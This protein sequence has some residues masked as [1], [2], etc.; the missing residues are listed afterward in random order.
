[1]RKLAR[2]ERIEFLRNHTERR[3]V[4]GAPERLMVLACALAAIASGGHGSEVRGFCA[5]AGLP[6]P[7]HARVVHPPQQRGHRQ[8]VSF[9]WRRQRTGFVRRGHAVVELRALRQEHA[10]LSKP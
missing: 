10:F 2:A 7:A 1:M 4:H 5:A 6:V 9:L 8:A 3:E